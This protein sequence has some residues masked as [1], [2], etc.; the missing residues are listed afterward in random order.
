MS[1]REEGRSYALPKRPGKQMDEQT[2]SLMRTCTSRSTNDSILS[3]TVMINDNEED[4]RGECA[5][6]LN[7]VTVRGTE[8]LATADEVER[9]F[10]IFS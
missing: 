4:H 5:L 1:V 10:R 7:G 9:S 3:M 8:V 2:A 6:W